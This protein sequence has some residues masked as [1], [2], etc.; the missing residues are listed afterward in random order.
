MSH[1]VPDKDKRGTDR[2]LARLVMMMF[3]FCDREMPN[4]AGLN[5]GKSIKQLPPRALDVVARTAATQDR[6]TDGLSAGAP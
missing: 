6:R 4:G 5:R 2:P 1:R 3:L